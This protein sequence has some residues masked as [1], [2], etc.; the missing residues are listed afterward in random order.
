M[1]RPHV[2]IFLVNLSF[3]FFTGFRCKQEICLINVLWE[4]SN[5]VYAFSVKNKSTL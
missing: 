5:A 2:S 1:S 3:F 4:K